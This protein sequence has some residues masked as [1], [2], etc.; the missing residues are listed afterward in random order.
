MAITIDKGGLVTDVLLIDLR[1]AFDTVNS[2]IMLAKLKG[3][4]INWIEH[5]WLSSY[6][7]DR[8]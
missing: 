6:L 5:N 1:K 8:R 4:G 2:Y 3:L 7:T